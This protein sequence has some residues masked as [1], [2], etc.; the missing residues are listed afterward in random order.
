MPAAAPVPLR[1]S[2]DIAQNGPSDPQIPIAANAIAASWIA[3]T[4]ARAAIT[5]PAAPEKA[6]AAIYHRRSAARSELLP[7]MTIPKDAARYGNALTNP[8]I[9]LLNPEKD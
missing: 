3:G 1:N 6:D 7:I 2:E 4:S 9:T 5:S 8:T